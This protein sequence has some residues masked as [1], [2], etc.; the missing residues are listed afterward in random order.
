MQAPPYWYF[1][2]FGKGKGGDI[3]VYVYEVPWTALPAPINTAF[4]DD[5]LMI[6]MNNSPN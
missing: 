6:M 1:L 5:G 2:Y 4:L 3:W